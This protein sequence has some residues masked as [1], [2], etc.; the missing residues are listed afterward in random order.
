M[1]R[2]AC[3]KCDGNSFEIAT[4]SPKNGRFKKTVIQ[5]AFCGTPIAASDFL[6]VGE[7]TEKILARLDEI[8]KRLK[9]IAP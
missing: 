1:A 7:Q 5:C 3:P 6:N 8:E 9:R 2:T 4:I